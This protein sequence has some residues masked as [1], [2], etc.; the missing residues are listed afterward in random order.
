M[1]NP[2]RVP[3]HLFLALLT[4]S[5]ANQAALKR[6]VTPLSRTSTTKNPKEIRT[7]PVRNN[8]R[9]K[10]KRKQSRAMTTRTRP[11]RKSLK[12]MAKLL[13]IKTRVSL[14]LIRNRKTKRK[15]SARSPP[16]KPLPSNLTRN[17]TQ[18]K[19]AEAVKRRSRLS[20]LSRRVRGR[21]RVTK[22]WKYP[23]APR[24]IPRSP[25]PPSGRPM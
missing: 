24:G 10:R 1:K 20:S 11:F 2:R 6:L 18:L 17:R 3:V 12:K 21:K 8:P 16:R 23:P 13:L 5:E 25:F 4:L 19:V 22:T 15:K 7:C 9:P 14:W